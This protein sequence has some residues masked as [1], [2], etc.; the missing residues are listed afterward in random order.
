MT[1]T[2]LRQAAS[3]VLSILLCASTFAQQA[4]ADG[5]NDEALL[6]YDEA[7]RL[8]PQNLALVGRCAALRSRL[9]REHVDKAEQLALAGKLPQAKEELSSAMRI[10]PSN[11]IVAE[12]YAQMQSM[13]DD[14]PALP[15]LQI[16]G[17]PRLKTQPGRHTLDLRGDTRT[18]Y[19]QLAQT[20]GTKVTFD[21]DVISHPVRMQL[22][23][24]DFNTA[25]SILGT[26]TGTFWRP[27]DAGLM[28]VA[29]DSPEKRRQFGLQ[30]EQTFPLPSSAS[31]EEMTELLRMLR[32][33]T[34]A[35]RIDLD[36]TSHTITMR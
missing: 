6:A 23:K 13:H 1:R 3:L 20:F 19:E 16:P 27:L 26:V 10:D 36:A 17:I 9:I 28:F 2:P 12:R 8:A 7:A 25:A 22:D 24:V 5:R 21:P 29:P 11:K 34:G 18:A 4:E 31:A 30:A 32:E 14:E 15:N 33:I 35:T